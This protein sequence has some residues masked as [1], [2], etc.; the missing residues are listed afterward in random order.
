MTLLS[1]LAL[2][3]LIWAGWWSHARA[4]AAP[5]SLA[6]RALCATVLGFAQLI[7]ASLALGWLGR[8]TRGHVVAAAVLVSAAVLATGWRRPAAP[9]TRLRGA[10][11]PVGGGGWA[12]LNR[13]LLA[14][15]GVAGVAALA[16]AVVGAPTSFDGLKYHLPLAL[17]MLQE[18]RLAIGPTYNPVFEG[19][20]RNA[21]L[22]FAW[23]L[24]F[25]RSDRWVEL[26]QA[27]FLLLGMLAVYCLA[28]RLSSG[29]PAS[30]TAALLLPFAPVVL[31]QI[32]TNYTDVVGSAL[33]L[34]AVALLLAAVGSRALGAAG[35][36]GAAVGLLMG[37]K[38]SGLLFATI[39]VA[40]FTGA[41][42]LGL[43]RPGRRVA[44]VLLAMALAAGLGL[45]AYARNWIEY[46]NPLFPYRQSL[47]GLE[48]PGPRTAEQVFGVPQTRELHPV[49]RVLRSWQAVGEASET[50]IFGGFGFT[51]P[52]L[53]LAT[54]VSAGVA[55]H[56]RDGPRLA[57]VALFAGLFV[58]TPLHFRVRF[59]IY[60]LGLGAVSLAHL[61][62]QPRW[63]RG[64]RAALAAAAVAV[65]TVSLA[66][67]GARSYRFLLPGEAALRAAL[68]DPC[69]HGHPVA[70]RPALGWVRAS[71][72]AGGRVVA[73]PTDDLFRYCLWN[74]R[75]TNRVDFAQ[76]ESP[77]A[78]LAT[79]ERRPG[80]WLVLPHDA[81]AYR[82]FTAVRERFVDLYVDA[83]ATVAALR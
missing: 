38:L 14:L 64:A 56:R 5:L 78:L 58:A 31:A 52:L 43:G 29:R 12:L 18:E 6:E 34:A 21:A 28:R 1:F 77:A 40:V 20:P 72:P 60:L 26:A 80:S 27:P 68:A 33:L 19:Y 23:I 39:F 24:A 59:V 36:F 49:A 54:L 71:A 13:T 70:M 16:R 42:M 32:T 47:P 66:Q 74:A 30:A 62:E 76:P 61:L 4:W 81:A 9:G 50:G 3:A 10:A 55:V 65:S 79:A 57:V 22:W 41:T 48:L 45:D 53:G 35:A 15:A 44:A 82:H 69:R 63:P 11:L 7:G 25:F 17:M 83:A 75:F 73:F 37:T 2:H 67:V 46:G 51:W 8:L